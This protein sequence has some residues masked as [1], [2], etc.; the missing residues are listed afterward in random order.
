MK[1]YIKLVPLFTA[2]IMLTIFSTGLK[3][4]SSVNLQDGQKEEISDQI[5][6]VQIEAKSGESGSL[7][8]DFEAA[9]GPYDPDVE[10]EESSEVKEDAFGFVSDE[11]SHLEVVK[12]EEYV[13]SYFEIEQQ[14]GTTG[15]TTK[16][17]IDIS[18]PWTG[19]YLY[20]DMVVEGSANIDESFEMENLGPGDE[21]LPDW[22]DL[23]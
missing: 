23:F 17:H 20:E 3:V 14:A 21:G 10:D 7:E 12:G 9:E 11:E 4:N 15:G 18:S 16:R 5:W 22:K 13:G 19:A 8:Q 1:K 2:V 6:A